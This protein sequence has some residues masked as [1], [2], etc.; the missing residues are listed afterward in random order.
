MFRVYN[1]GIGFCLVVPGD[2]A[3]LTMSIVRSHNKIAH[4]IGHAVRDTE[5]KV[6]IKP[7]KL[8]GRDNKFY[9]S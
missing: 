6:F 5:K 2:Q 1:M 7:F 4:R 3:D 9:A 8:V